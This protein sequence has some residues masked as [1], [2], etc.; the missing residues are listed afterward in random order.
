MFIPLLL[1]P[2]FPCV[3]SLSLSLAAPPHG[4]LQGCLAADLVSLP[5]RPLGTW[6]DFIHKDV[7]TN[8]YV[9]ELSEKQS[10]G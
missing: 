7:R 9:W 2:Q 10:V 4:W 3:L 8:N 1:L 5:C 6:V